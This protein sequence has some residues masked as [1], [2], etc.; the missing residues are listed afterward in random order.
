MMRMGMCQT[1][2][3]KPRESH[4]DER[5]ARRY[6]STNQVIGICDSRNGSNADSGRG[7][8]VLSSKIARNSN[9]RLETHR[10][11]NMA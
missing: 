9:V 2:E 4:G 5:L 11:L 6:P 7:A 8:W 1:A 10:V 3:S